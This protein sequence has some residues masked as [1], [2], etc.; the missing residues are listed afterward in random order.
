MAVTLSAP[1]EVPSRPPRAVT[2]TTRK[3]GL[4]GSHTASLRTCPWRDP[5]W[6]LWGHAS[7]R[8][9]YSRN[10]DCYFEMH[11]KERWS[12]VKKKGTKYLHW[13]GRNTIPIYMHERYPGVP[14]SV[15]YP[16]ER[17]FEEFSHIPR[18]YFANTAAWM[19][20][21]AIMEGAT[22]VGLWGINYSTESE[23]ARQ[24][25]SME[26]WL[27]VL[28]GMRIQIILPDE[29][30]LLGEPALLYGY[31]SHDENGVLVPEYQPKEFTPSEKPKRILRP[32]EKPPKL[33]IPPDL[34]R[35]ID[36]EESLVERPDWAKPREVA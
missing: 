29:C 15:R 33:V 20:A 22:T 25:G 18:R 11:R 36:E 23:Y 19:T 2:R 3:I 28:G 31:E 17:V 35:E 27:G 21:L 5:T 10:L 16:K 34:Q 4:V 12:H 6:E 14:A 1:G 26:H 13:L 24:R 32:G 30:T 7:S 8:S 9:W